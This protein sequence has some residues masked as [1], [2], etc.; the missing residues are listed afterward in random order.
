MKIELL[1]DKERRT[2]FQLLQILYDNDQAVAIKE[3]TST[4][5]LSKVTL[6]K[7]IN[8]LNDL[9]EK[10]KLNCQLNLTQEKVQLAEDNQFLVNDLVSIMLSDSIPYQMLR[11][12]AFHEHFNVTKLAQ[13][14]LISE[15]TLN[16]QLAYLN[17]LLEEFDIGISQGKQIGSELQWRYFFYEL[18]RISLSKTEKDKLTAD[19]NRGHLTNLAEKLTNAKLSFEQLEELSLWLAISH[20]RY[21][22]HKEKQFNSHLTFDYLLDNVFYQRLERLMLRYLSRFAMEFDR[23]EAQSLM[24]FLHTKAILPISSMEYLLGFGGPISDNISEAV[25]LLRKAKIIGQ[26]TKEEVIY[27]LGLFYAQ[28][29]FLKGALTTAPKRNDNIKELLAEDDQD[30]LDLVITHLFVIAET[31]TRLSDDF[32]E[33]L[34]FELMELLIFSIEKHHKPLIVSLDIGVNAVKKEL[35][36]LM[37]RKYLEHNLNYQFVYGDSMSICDCVISYGDRNRFA[38]NVYFHLKSYTSSL[39]L[40]KME[41]FLAEQLK[42]KNDRC[43]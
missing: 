11:H 28:M 5:N 42:L 41:E 35:V 30:K 38:D 12:F 24:I 43:S 34:T 26:Q 25:W 3:V 23:F 31:N 27:G 20:Q 7:Y 1:M 9:F 14:L 6:I 32:L 37:I 16:R 13:D 2:Q 39:E 17:S 4:L 21:F 36:S 33:N 22:F 18:L 15:P 8:H 40:K 10:N 19:I 29:Y